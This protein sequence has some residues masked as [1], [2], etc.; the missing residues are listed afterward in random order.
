MSQEIE[1]ING[2][3]DID[4][5]IQES[6]INNFY[7]L[8]WIP[9]YSFQNIEH[10]A[11]G[12]HGSVYS[13]KLENGIK[14]NWNFIKHDWEYYLI[15]Y[16]VAFK[17]INS[18]YDIGNILN[19]SIYSTILDLG[20]CKLENE[21]TRK[22]HIYSFGGFMYEIVAA[23]RPFADD[24]YILHAIPEWYLDLMYRCWN[25]DP[26]ERPTAD[27]LFDLFYEISD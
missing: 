9:Y 20:L 2:N 18:R 5:I 23:Q 24:G 6:Q 17:E 14:W 27:E 12:G 13:I 15:G 8:Q 19:E 11:D 25:D 1:N 3:T 22:N 7:K 26:S 4:K 16:K 21:F 10:A